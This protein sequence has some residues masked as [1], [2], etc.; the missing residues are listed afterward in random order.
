MFTHNLESGD[1]AEQV[2]RLEHV[3]VSF[4]CQQIALHTL[5]KTA[6]RSIWYS[7]SLQYQ[8]AGKVRVSSAMISMKLESKFKY[9]ISTIETVNSDSDSEVVPFL[10][11]HKLP[12]VPIE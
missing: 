9:Q 7:G 5:R 12:F 2:P 8:E 3:L 4:N 6:R 10:Y 11:H 1:G